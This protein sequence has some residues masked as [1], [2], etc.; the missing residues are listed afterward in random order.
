MLRFRIERGQSVL[1]IIVRQLIVV[2]C[3]SV[4]DE[5]L[6]ERL[7]AWDDGVLQPLSLKRRVVVAHVQRLHLLLDVDLRRFRA[8]NLQ[9]VRMSKF[10]RIFL[11]ILKNHDILKV[12]PNFPV[13]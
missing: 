3:L 4:A 7:E 9:K 8:L 11:Q 12:F 13:S 5:M 6:H 10:S 2:Q 1:Q